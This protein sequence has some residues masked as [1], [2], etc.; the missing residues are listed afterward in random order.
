MEK[1]CSKSVP[2]LI[3]PK[4]V[5][6]ISLP[7]EVNGINQGKQAIQTKKKPMFSKVTSPSGTTRESPPS[8]RE[9]EKSVFPNKKRKH[10]EYIEYQTIDPNSDVFQYLDNCSAESISMKCTLCNDIR[11]SGAKASEL[12]EH[13][14][15]LHGIFYCPP[16]NRYFTSKSSLVRH[17]SIHSGI[18]PFSCSFCRKTFYRK[19]KCKE[20][21]FRSHLRMVDDV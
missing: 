21:V 14:C 9:K 4:A 8:Q 1:S 13:L 7:I 5:P 12:C 10:E 11:F 17:I 6:Q 3:L 19:D 16:C 18:H 20:H 2:R 15:G